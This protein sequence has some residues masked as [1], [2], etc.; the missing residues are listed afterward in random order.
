MKK[1]IYASFAIGLLVSIPQAN[2]SWRSFTHSVGSAFSHIAGG[3]AVS[4]DKHHASND[5]SAQQFSPDQD[6]DI[7]AKA[8]QGFQLIGKTFQNMLHK[9][10]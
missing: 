6:K 3:E 1:M 8:T 7:V 9:L 10:H 5:D 4:V 2:A